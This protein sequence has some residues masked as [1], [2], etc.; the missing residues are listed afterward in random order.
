MISTALGGC[1]SFPLHQVLH[2]AIEGD[3]S[4]QD[5]VLFPTGQPP[6][7]SKIAADGVLEVGQLAA[8]VHAVHYVCGVEPWQ[9]AQHLSRCGDGVCLAGRRDL[10]AG[11]LQVP[12]GPTTFPFQWWRGNGHDAGCCVHLAGA[13]EA[14]GQGKEEAKQTDHLW[15]RRNQAIIFP[16]KKKT[17]NILVVFLQM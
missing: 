5:F 1:D 15:G 10:S 9:R 17:D 16:E 2:L 13:T 6:C 11:D 7:C 12:P 14:D 4:G 3:P 8:G